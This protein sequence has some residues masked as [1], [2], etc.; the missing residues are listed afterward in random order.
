MRAARELADRSVRVIDLS[1]ACHLRWQQVAPISPPAATGAARPIAFTGPTCYEEDVIGEWKL[2]PA[3][4]AVGAPLVV[5]GVNGY[6][7]GWNTG[8]GGVAP[9]EVAIIE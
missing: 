1:R 9:A 5:A 3:R 2:D 8:F 7:L 6:A 4:F